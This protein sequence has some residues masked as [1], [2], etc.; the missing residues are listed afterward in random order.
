MNH[1]P[2]KSKNMGGIP[3]SNPTL[4]QSNGDLLCPAAFGLPVLRVW[5]LKVVGGMIQNLEP[6][7]LIG[8]ILQIQIYHVAQENWPSIVQWPV[9]LTWASSRM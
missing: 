6:L 4:H 5:G 1:R 9:S 2:K 8:F 3:S 7:K